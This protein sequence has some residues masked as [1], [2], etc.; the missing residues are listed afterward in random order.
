MTQHAMTVIGQAH[1]ERVSVELD[2]D[3]YNIE[4]D[5][6]NRQRVERGLRRLRKLQDK[7]GCRK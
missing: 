6:Y 5:T 2:A 4:Q 7:A 1:L 3:T